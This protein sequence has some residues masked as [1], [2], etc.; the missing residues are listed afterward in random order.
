MFKNHPQCSGGKNKRATATPP[1]QVESALRIDVA[2]YFGL[3]SCNIRESEYEGNEQFGTLCET[4]EHTTVA[5]INSQLSL[6]LPQRMALTG[7][8]IVD[9]YDVSVS[10]VASNFNIFC[11]HNSN[12]IFLTF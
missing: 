9:V 2:C 8:E 1:K 3:P 5:L 6:C 4:K 12:H 7:V 11:N 10:F